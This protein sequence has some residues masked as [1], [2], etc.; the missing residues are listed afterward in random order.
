MK[1]QSAPAPAPEPS[2]GITLHNRLHSGH[3]YQTAIDEVFRTALRSLPGP[4]DVSAYPV[5]RAWFRM[6]VVA[7]DG[8]SWSMSVPVHQGPRAEDLADTVRA[9]CARHC[10][11]HPENARR[12]AGRPG[13]GAAGTSYLAPNAGSPRDGVAVVPSPAA[14]GGTSK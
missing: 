1:N 5:G 12:R 4:W 9:A 10:R 3:L 6:D 14:V 13:D 2:G 8:A 11:L 7:P